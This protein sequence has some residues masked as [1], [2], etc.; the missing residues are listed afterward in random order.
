MANELN[1]ALATSGL[2]VTAQRY[3]AGAAVGSAI[4]LTEVG[5]SGF[6]SGNMTGSAGTYQLAFIA[7]STN[8]G[9]GDI[10]WDG[11]NEVP[12]STLTAAQVNTECDTALSDVGLTSTVTGRIDA[13][14]SS[15]LATSG[16]TAPANSDITAIKAK[17][18]N[19]PA[20]PAA[21]GDIPSAA[22]I[23]DE[24]WDTQTSALTTSGA[25]GTRLKNS[26]TVAT[27]GAQLAAALS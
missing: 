14:V 20:S 25:I 7:S 5:S 12:V 13:A 8:V 15:R 19:L 10:I 23:A 16:Y 21:T 17:T 2:T 22:T 9:S 24:V 26:S 6:Y 27:T 11:T 18:D 1:I 4:S 3:Q